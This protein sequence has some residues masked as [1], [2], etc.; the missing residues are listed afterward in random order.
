MAGGRRPWDSEQMFQALYKVR[1]NSGVNTVSLIWVLQQLGAERLAPPIPEDVN[2]SADARDFL[3]KCFTVCVL[4]LISMSSTSNRMQRY[5][6]PEDRPTAIQLL[7][8]P[9]MALDEEFRF[10]ESSL[11]QAIGT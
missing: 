5:R 11:G 2:L 3:T 10:K 9:F 4:I 1:P 7:E 8:H 6:I